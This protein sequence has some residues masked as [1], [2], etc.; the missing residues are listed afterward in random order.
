MDIERFIRVIRLDRER[1]FV[2]VIETE[3]ARETERKS[4]GKRDL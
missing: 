2:C 4:E 1:V 3:K